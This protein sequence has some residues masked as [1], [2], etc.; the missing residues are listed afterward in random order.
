MRRRWSRTTWAAVG[1]AV[2]L[3]SCQRKETTPAAVPE[4]RYLVGTP[5]PGTGGAWYYPEETFDGTQTGLATVEAAH[6]QHLTA[7]GEVYRSDLPAVAHQTLQLPAI[8]RLTNLENGRQILVRVNDRG[9]PEQGRLLTVTPATARLLQMP[10]GGA[11]RVRLD[12]DSVLS[13]RLA[14][15]LDGGPK[16]A[17]QAAPVEP[18]QEQALPAPGAGSV[19][20]ADQVVAP[21][22]HFAAHDDATVPDPLPPELRQ[23]D[24]D[25]GELWVDGGR[26]NQRLYADQVAAEI[27]GAVQARGRG[28]EAVYIVREGPFQSTADADAALDQARRV[29]VTGARIIVE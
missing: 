10:L 2:A 3:A 6:A 20:A 15:Q 24:A 25:P 14:E 13:R 5:W 16:L 12:V 19:A 11:T 7:D 18:V 28:H 1:A 27:G 23:G 4:T 22:D 17:L 21:A 29:G 8:V 9:P 26:F